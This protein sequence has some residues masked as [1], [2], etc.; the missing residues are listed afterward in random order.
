M[1]SFIRLFAVALVGVISF[2]SMVEA[3]EA[4]T[5]PVNPINPSGSALTEAH[6]AS[7]KVL[8]LPV[9]VIPEG[10]PADPTKRCPQWEDEL[11]AFGL[12]VETFSFVAW[13]ESRCNIL[14]HNRTL[15]KNKTQDRGLLQINSSWVTV[16]A[17]ECASQRGDL[18]VLFDVRCNLAV[19]RYLYRNGGLRHW[20]L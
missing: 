11:A 19:A 15:N 20:K 3:A 12:P 5:N 6:K 13:R 2:G 9:E 4:P 8:V 7:E 14:A 10:V 18:S 16:T 17:K 1:R